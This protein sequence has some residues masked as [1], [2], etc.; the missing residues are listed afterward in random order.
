M[1]DPLNRAFAE[2]PPRRLDRPTG[3][4]SQHP[5]AAMHALTEELE[6][7]RAQLLATMASPF[8]DEGAE[9]ELIP[10]VK[11]GTSELGT[12]KVIAR[13][14]EPAYEAL[15]SIEV[16]C[17]HDASA[18]GG[19]AGGRYEVRAKVA[20]SR[21]DAAGRAHCERVFA[22]HEIDG[23]LQIDSADLKERIADEIREL[24]KPA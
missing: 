10:V 5:T 9:A 20:V 21:A 12:V 6:S 19:D 22:V 17:D 8:F 2:A 24:G 11:H 7:L 13:K 15:A 16:R 4:I 1:D 23:G 14:R 18:D 3:E